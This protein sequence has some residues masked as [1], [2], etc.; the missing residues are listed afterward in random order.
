MIAVLS[1]GNEAGAC[2]F[3]G[4]DFTVLGRHQWKQSKQSK[5]S[6]PFTTSTGVVTHILQQQAPTV[7]NNRAIH[8]L[9]FILTILITMVKQLPTVTQWLSQSKII[10]STSII[11]DNHLKLSGAKRSCHVLDIPN[12]KSLYKVSLQ[13]TADDIEDNNEEDEEIDLDKLS[14]LTGVKLPKRD[15]DW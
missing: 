6:K 7:P 12:L 10:M 4:K 3:C 2:D 14:L 8:R 15:S 9:Q 11:V 5:Q 1:K 13:G